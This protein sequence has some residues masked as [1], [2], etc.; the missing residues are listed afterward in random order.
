[1][2]YLSI[3]ISFVLFFPD[4]RN[5]KKLL[6]STIMKFIKDVERNMGVQLF[7]MAGMKKSDGSIVR[8]KYVLIHLHD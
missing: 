8:Q 5:A 2:N 1:M 4:N 7:I 6:P 3:T